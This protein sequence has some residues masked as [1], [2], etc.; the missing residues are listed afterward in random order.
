MRLIISPDASRDT[1]KGITNMTIYGVFT[2]QDG[3]WKLVQT[4]FN[5][6]DAERERDYLRRAF[7]LRADIFQQHA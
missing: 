6:G 7:G 1:H 2:I 5:W 3:A 4:Y